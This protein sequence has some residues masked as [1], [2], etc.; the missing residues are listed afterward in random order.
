VTNDA[1]SLSKLDFRYGAQ[2]QLAINDLTV[3]I[4]TGQITA[5][6]GPNGAGKTTLLHLMLGLYQPA[7]GHIL[8]HGKPF[9]HYSKRELSQFIGFVPQIESTP[10][11]FTVFEYVLLGRSPYLATFEMPSDGDIQIAVETLEKLEL[12]DLK[13]RPI[14]E[15][16]GGERQ[17][18]LLARALAQQ[19]SVLLL[20][21]PTAHLDLGN[22]SRILHILQDLASHG[23]TIVFTTHDPNI[24]TFSAK[25][26]VLMSRGK[27]LEF[28]SMEEVITTDK[29]HVVYRVP[30]QVKRLENRLIIILE[31][32]N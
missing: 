5:I 28:G 27:I 24:A 9:N 19:T 31:N 21:E 11:N 1:F 12:T 25:N 30:I 16:S 8:I 20:D 15:L 23:I 6:L 2:E 7:N 4:P 29:L 26:F 22:Q 32:D 10:F 13:E 18:V 3:S 17:M 14:P